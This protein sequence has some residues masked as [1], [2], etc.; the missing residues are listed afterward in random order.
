[1]KRFF[2]KYKIP[3]TVGIT[4]LSAALLALIFALAVAEDAK[5]VF[6]NQNVSSNTSVIVEEEIIYVESLPSESEEEPTEEIIAPLVITSPSAQDTTVTDP[7][8]AI[9][10]TSDT[11]TVVILSVATA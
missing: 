11:A 8:F 7:N 5:E 2:K 9:S 6:A 1:M 3:L 4:I 10:G